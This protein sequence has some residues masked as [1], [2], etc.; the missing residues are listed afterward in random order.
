MTLSPVTSRVL[1]TG[2]RGFTGRYVRDAITAQGHE[3]YGL[4]QESSNEPNTVVADLLDPDALV[5]AFETVRPDFVVHLAAIAFVDRVDVKP[6]YD[7]NL[8]GTLNLFE[9]ASRANV[10]PVR[11]VIAS[12]ANVYGNPPVPLVGEVV[13]PAPVNHYAM[14]KLAMEHMTRT[15]ADRFNITIVRPFN[16]T[17]V[18][19]S[20]QFLIPKLVAHFRDRRS[21]ISLGNLDVSREFNDV[22]MVAQV[23]ANLLRREVASNGLTINI[24]SGKGYALGDV[25]AMLEKLCE[26]V[27]QVKSDPKL[28]RA[29]ELK[30]LVGVPDRLNAL[31]PDLPAFEL[32]DT[33]TWM[34]GM[35][36]KTIS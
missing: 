12:S 1:L 28:V 18:G 17:G 16:Y 11:F 5:A 2:A 4:S 35:P 33:L 15:W 9:A 23:Y 29:N 22:R 10:K 8:F 32:S 31:M 24:C 30:V 26:H 20:E 13:C 27:I 34:L 6:F 25:I 36:G 14:S 7:V 3:V 21:E 19:Q